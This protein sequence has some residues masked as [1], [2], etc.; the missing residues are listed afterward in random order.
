MLT[1]FDYR[2]LACLTDWKSAREVAMELH[3]DVDKV[4]KSLEKLLEERLV[5]HD[6]PLYINRYGR[7]PKWR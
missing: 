6:G 5:W 7:V 4:K 3:V 1:E 2:V